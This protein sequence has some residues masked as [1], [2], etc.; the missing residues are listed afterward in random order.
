MDSFSSTLSSISVVSCTLSNLRTTP[1][2][3]LI[4]TV[5]SISSPLTSTLSKLIETSPVPEQSSS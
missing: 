5:L 4:I 3:S 1:T 2:S